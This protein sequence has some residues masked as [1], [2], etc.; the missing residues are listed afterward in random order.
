ML[1]AN[2]S[3]IN[4]W[5]NKALG[6]QFMAKPQRAQWPCSESWKD[7][8]KIIFCIIP[9]VKSRHVLGEG[10][11]LGHSQIIKGM[12]SQ[13]IYLLVQ[14]SSS[15]GFLLRECQK[16]NF[17]ICKVVHRKFQSRSCGEKGTVL[18]VACGYPEGWQTSSTWKMGYLPTVKKKPGWLHGSFVFLG[19]LLLDSRPLNV[20]I[21]QVHCKRRFSLELGKYNLAIRM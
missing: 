17:L 3:M 20:V 12:K 10:A 6:N 13:V 11:S 19:L 15:V 9:S 2:Q 21:I 18:Q 4:F 16:F 1:L 14:M 7:H 8:P 5:L